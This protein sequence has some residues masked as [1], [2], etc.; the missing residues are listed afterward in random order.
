MLCNEKNWEKQKRWIFWNKTILLHFLVLK[1]EKVNFE[2]RM[3][4]GGMTFFETQA[5]WIVIRL[6]WSTNPYMCIKK[7]FT[8]YQI[9]VT[10]TH[11][12]WQLKRETKDPRALET[13]EC[14][15]KNEN[16]KKAVWMYE[17]ECN[18][19]KW[20]LFWMEQKRERGKVHKGGGVHVCARI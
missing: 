17:L 7:W 19:W 15:N 10:N 1:G 20:M 16:K 9:M 4:G 12:K 5:L 13:S 11:K 6:I 2:N 14:V 3:I 18:K 8:L